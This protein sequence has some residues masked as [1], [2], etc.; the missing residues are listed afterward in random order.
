M[1]YEVTLAG[2][3]GEVFVIDHEPRTPLETGT[4]VGVVIEPGGAT[5]VG[6]AT[7]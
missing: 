2:V 4:E 7:S 3:S 6:A 1:E 5:L